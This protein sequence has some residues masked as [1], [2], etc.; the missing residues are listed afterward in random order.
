MGILWN[1]LKKDILTELEKQISHNSVWRQI[2][3]R[4][5]KLESIA[6]KPKP[7]LSEE[8]QD[9]NKKL[10]KAVQQMEK[11][12][13]R[14]Q[15][16]EA[17]KQEYMHR[18]EA[19]ERRIKEL[20]ERILVR[21]SPLTPPRPG[22]EAF[23][24]PPVEKV[25]IAGNPIEINTRLQQTLDMAAIEEFLRQS[26][27]DKKELFIKNIEKYQK[28]LRRFVERIKLDE[29]DE[30]SLSEDVTVK[31]WGIVSKN[32]LANTM[33][34]VYRGQEENP[35]FYGP[36]LQQLNAYLSR[37]G[38]YTRDVVPGNSFTEKELDDMAIIPKN[39]LNKGDDGIIDEVEQLPYYMDY[40]NDDGD[41]ES[42]QCDGKMV[43]LKYQLKE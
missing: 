20:E 17:D 9:L 38:V 2:D 30:D 37:C 4:L 24:L 23:K 41:K 19:V 6:V 25:F 12:S 15:A 18:F 32:L 29:Y 33:V 10:E 5:Q 28:N 34:A 1:L 11:L 42:L 3:M 14:V 22:I 39:T 8:P 35:E 36:F 40:Y 26:D 27:Y 21:E 43:V 7:P 31:F 13:A 16:L